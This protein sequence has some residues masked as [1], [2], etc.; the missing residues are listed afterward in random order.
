MTAEAAMPVLP[1]QDCGRSASRCSSRAIFTNSRKG[2]AARKTATWAGTLASNRRL[3]RHAP[4]FVEASWSAY[5]RLSKNVR[6]IGPASSSDASPLTCWPPREGSPKCAF[7]NAAISASVD[8]DGC[9]KNL[10]CSIPSAAVRPVIKPREPVNTFLEN[11]LERCPAAKLELLHPVELTLGQ[12]HR[13]VEAQRTEWR[14]PDQAD[15][16]GGTNGITL[17]ILQSQTRSGVGGRL[18]RRRSTAGH[19]DFASGGPGSRALVIKQPA[20]VSINSALQAHFLRQEPDQHLQL[21]RTAPI[22]G[23]A[24]RVLRAVRIDV[25]RTDAV[26]GEAADKIRAHLELIE[27]PQLGVA[28]LIENAAL[29]VGQANDIGNQRGVV[30]RVDR[31]LQIADVAADAGEVLLEIDQ[32]AVGRVLVVVERIVIERI[33]QRRGQRLAAR[34]LLADRQR[35]LAIGVAPETKPC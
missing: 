29:N 14:C 17:V 27:H 1:N 4:A 21:V 2:W 30:L 22:F 9:S 31:A 3:T 11:A 13:I 6:C 19:V 33:A 28:D 12:G 35:R 8:G 18:W 7:V 16:H 34:Q 23:G 24:E 10:G 26:R 20:G 32:E 15:T 25:A 5:F